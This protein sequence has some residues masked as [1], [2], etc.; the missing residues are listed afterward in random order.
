VIKYTALMKRA[1][2]LGSRWAVATVPSV[3]KTAK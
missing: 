1:R 3:G 2:V